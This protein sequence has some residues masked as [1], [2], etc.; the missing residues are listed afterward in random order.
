MVLPDDRKRGQ[1]P[2]F[3]IKWFT[4]KQTL[5]NSPWGK[6]PHYSL[7]TNGHLNF[8]KKSKENKLRFI[9]GKTS[10]YSLATNSHIISELNYEETK[11]KSANQ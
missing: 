7:A 6:K 9:P 10:H 2:F 4:Q 8:E 3:P 11:K 5:G 1:C